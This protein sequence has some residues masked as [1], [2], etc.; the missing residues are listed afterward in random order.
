MLTFLLKLLN[1]TE[2]AFAKK[3][4]VAITYSLVDNLKE[5]LVWYLLPLVTYTYRR[6]NPCRICFI[7]LDGMGLYKLMPYLFIFRDK[8]IDL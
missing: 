4:G 3:R 5:L 8:F 7:W 2:E 1:I 6:D